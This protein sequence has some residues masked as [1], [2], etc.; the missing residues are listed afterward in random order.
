M[1]RKLLKTVANLLIFGEIWKEIGK[2]TI[3]YEL[4]LCF[5]YHLAFF[6]LSLGNKS[7]KDTIL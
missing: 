7:K 6:F 5:V 2:K 4:F 3:F 1:I